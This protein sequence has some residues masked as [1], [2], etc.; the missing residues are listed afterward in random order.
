[1]VLGSAAAQP[2]SRAIIDVHLHAESVDSYIAIQSDTRWF[3]QDL[4]RATS[5]DELMTES[6]KALERFNVVRAITS[7]EIVHPEKLSGLRPVKFEQLETR[8]HLNTATWTYSR[9]IGNLLGGEPCSTR[10]PRK[11]DSY[12]NRFLLSENGGGGGAGQGLVTAS[13]D[14][15]RS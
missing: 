12:R 5:D 11:R 2:P 6:L 9:L 7:E 14:V 15:D 10:A 8:V 3:P 13:M 4:K 1:M